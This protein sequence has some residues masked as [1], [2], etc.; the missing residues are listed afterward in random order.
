MAKATYVKQL[1]VKDANGKI[2]AIDMPGEYVF[3]SD[4]KT[5]DAH[6]IDNT[7]H[8]TESQRELILALAEDVLRNSVPGRGVIPSS[9]DAAARLG[10]TLPTFNRKLDNVCDKLD[11]FG[12][13][14]LRG[15]RNKLASNRRARL[16]E[17]AISTRLV[18]PEDLDTLDRR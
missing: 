15:G 7:I 18:T 1:V 5:L 4:G 9:A 13:S 11:K 16:V 14:G 2:V 8:L 3:S 12:V 6:V 17:Y 10:W